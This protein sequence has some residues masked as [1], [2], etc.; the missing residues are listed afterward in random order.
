MQPFIREELQALLAPYE[1]PCLS[2]YLPLG[3][4]SFDARPQ[5]LELKHALRQI[6]I[7]LDS[8]PD[9]KQSARSVME[10]IARL[11][12][13]ALPM[14]SAGTLAIFASPGF[15]RSWVFPE[16][17]PPVTIVSD[18]FHTK[19][20][21]KHV[22]EESAYYVLAL[23]K[24]NVT[25]YRGHDHELSVVPTPGMPRG[26]RELVGHRVDHS[27][28]K[29]MTTA[30]AG[31]GGGARFFG[32]GGSDANDAKEDLKSFFRMVDKAVVQATHARPAPLI[33]ATF[34]QHC[35]MFH[36]VSRNPLLVRE[37]IVGDP[38]AMKLDD[39][40]DRALQILGPLRERRLEKIADE[41]G[42]AVA[43]HRG[44]CDLSSISKAAVDGRVQALLVEDGR[45]VAGKLD[46]R[47]GEIMKASGPPQACAEDVLDDVSELVLAR[48]G[49]VHVLPPAM[50]PTDAGF[51]AIYRY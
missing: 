44:S 49:D 3:P 37:R 46:R 6:E 13:E 24:E 5:A 17:M 30:V 43:R 23:T 34:D 39:L 18:S 1:G 14:A 12:A 50:M 7:A 25:L 45:H 16:A 20:L 21:L 31:A 9:W 29:R 22:Q 42:V 4:I 38:E 10:T 19:P 33:L 47:T 2:V 41:Y 8:R 35:G 27:V 48:G 36:E 26:M 11:G 28:S 15:H 40:R 32:P 51:A